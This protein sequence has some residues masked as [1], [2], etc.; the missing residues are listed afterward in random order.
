MRAAWQAP[1]TSHG[2]TLRNDIATRYSCACSRVIHLST[3]DGTR[4]TDAMSNS[5]SSMHPTNSLSGRSL[6]VSASMQT[7]LLARTKASPSRISRSRTVPPV[8]RLPATF[9]ELT[10]PRNWRKPCAS[11]TAVRSA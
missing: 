4:R 3:L 9:V 7:T 8:L 6:T 5:L 10:A 11:V 2:A 1:E